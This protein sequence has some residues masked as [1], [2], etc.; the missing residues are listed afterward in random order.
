MSA[1]SY[2]GRL[3]K[4]IRLHLLL[5]IAGLVISGLTAF[6]IEWQLQYAHELIS[7]YR[8]DNVLTRW[9][10]LAYQGVRETNTTYQ[11]ISYGTDWLGFAHLIIAVAFVG[12]LKDP[13]RNIWVIE[14]GLAACFTI[15]PFAFVSGEIR[16]I[17]VFWRLID[18]LFGIV[19][20]LILWSC[21][22][23]IQVLEKIK[24]GAYGYTK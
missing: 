22:V 9:L 20:G 21:Y 19:G 8:W 15:L 13:V 5:F 18:C 11:F 10:E 12:P 7:Q 24:I 16:G 2:G 14:F 1:S 23:K 4:Q 17:P 3:E 6:P